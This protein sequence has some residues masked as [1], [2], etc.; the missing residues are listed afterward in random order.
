MEH[1]NYHKSLYF[2]ETKSLLDQS[3]ELYYRRFNL[4]FFSTM[5]LLNRFDRIFI[6]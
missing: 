5:A 3:L 6:T 2:S 1:H 4:K